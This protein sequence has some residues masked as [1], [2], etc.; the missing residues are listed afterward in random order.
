MEQ[1]YI[2]IQIITSTTH[3]LFAPKQKESLLLSFVTKHVT[4]QKIKGKWG[5]NNIK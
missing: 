4:L 5:T 2:F 3:E 1:E